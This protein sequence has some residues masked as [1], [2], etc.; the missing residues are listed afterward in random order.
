MLESISHKAFEGED[1][2][3]DLIIEKMARWG[4][5]FYKAQ[6]RGKLMRVN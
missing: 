2:L 5:V 4:L 6:I 1:Y 3:D